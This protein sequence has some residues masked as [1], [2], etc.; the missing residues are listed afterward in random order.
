MDGW[1]DMV[2]MATNMLFS[3]VGDTGYVDDNTYAVAAD[4]AF[5]YILLL[6]PSA[7]RSRLEPMSIV[8]LS[9]I[10]SVASLQIIKESCTKIA[11]L[12]DGSSDPPIMNY[13]TIGIASTTV[14][15]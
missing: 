12:S 11:G 2:M 7:G 14:G 9:V 1:I 6:C 4:I 3:G 13:I 5:D 10:M 8:I 15:K